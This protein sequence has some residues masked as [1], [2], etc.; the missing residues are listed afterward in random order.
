VIRIGDALWITTLA[1]IRA[2][3]H[4]RDNLRRFVKV[5]RGAVAIDAIA[6]IEVHD[7][8]VAIAMR[9]GT[10]HVLDGFD[11]LEAV[12]LVAPQLLEGRRLRWL[13]H[14]WAVHNLIG[15][16][17]MQIAAWLGAPRL[18]IAIHDATVP[19][20]LVVPVRSRASRY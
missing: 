8:R 16:P 19:R 2:G 3:I 10:E 6:R 20:S 5:G 15:H 11:A 7:D 9:D 12:L 1:A 13:R 14:A 18:G 4:A 17:A